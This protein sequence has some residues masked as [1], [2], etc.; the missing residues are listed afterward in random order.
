[1]KYDNFSA[2][3]ENNVISWQ[4][5]GELI[6]IECPDL[7]NAYLFPKANLILALVGKGNYPSTLIGFSEKG[8]RKFEVNAPEEFE[9]S[10]LTEHPTAGIA[11]VCVADKRIDGWMDWHFSVNPSTGE[12]KRHCPAY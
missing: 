8:T 4:I 6:F 7:D 11:V 2:D 3:K 9:F 10:Y 12:L 1:M 5:D